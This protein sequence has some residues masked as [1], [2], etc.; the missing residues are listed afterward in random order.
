V[1]D[2]GLGYGVLRHLAAPSVRAE[3]AALPQPRIT[4]NYLGQFDRQFDEAALFVP[5]GET[6][7][8]RRIRRRRW[9]TG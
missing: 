1:P 6:S 4:F 8:G 5:A 9:A 7:G 2:K 3:L